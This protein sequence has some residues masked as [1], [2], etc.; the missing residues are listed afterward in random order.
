MSYTTP[1]VNMA[2]LANAAELTRLT[3]TS[4]MDEKTV[5]S[6]FGQPLA[7]ENVYRVLMLAIN[8][9]LA[10]KLNAMP[11]GQFNKTVQTGG[12]TRGQTNPNVNVSTLPYSN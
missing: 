4:M 11:T 2:I 12:N 1:A 7:R 3:V 8:K 5:S 6:F 10:A 9:K